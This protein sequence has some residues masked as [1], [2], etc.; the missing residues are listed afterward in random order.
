MDTHFLFESVFPV[1]CEKI[2][3]K[4]HRQSMFLQPEFM[5]VLDLGPGFGSVS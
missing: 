2:S 5:T 1:F 4:I 3:L